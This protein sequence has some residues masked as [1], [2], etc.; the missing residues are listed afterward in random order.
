MNK[1]VVIL[2]IILS[3][4]LY[5]TI[6]IIHAIVVKTEHLLFIVFFPFLTLHAYYTS[7]HSREISLY[8]AF[9]LSTI[10]IIFN[11]VVITIFYLCFNRA[12]N[13]KQ[14]IILFLIITLILDILLIKYLNIRLVG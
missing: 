13:I 9:I 10:T 6:A 12:K 1:K 11:A 14:K 7:S 2:D 8:E 4:S 5:M 3:I